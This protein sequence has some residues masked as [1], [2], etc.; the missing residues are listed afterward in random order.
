MISE[1]L[2]QIGAVAKR[3]EVSPRTIK[4]YEELGLVE[5]RERSL[6]GFRLYGERDVSRLERILRLKGLGFSLSAIREI[7]AVRDE[8]QEATRATVLHE[9]IGR[10][11]ERERAVGRRIQELSEDLRSAESLRNELKQDI[12][13]CRQRLKALEDNPE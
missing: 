10:L 2:S 6:G 13:L 7:L 4:Y 3:L 11:E 5:P 8:A 9:S 12:A 1:E